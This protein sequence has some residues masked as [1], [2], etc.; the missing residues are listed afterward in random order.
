MFKFLA[1]IIIQTISSFE[2][3]QIA[4]VLAGNS[5][6]HGKTFGPNMSYLETDKFSFHEYCYQK[7]Q[8]GGQTVVGPTSLFSIIVLPQSFKLNLQDIRKIAPN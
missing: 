1:A 4:M 6:L 5:I 7:F 3:N 8:L 2:V